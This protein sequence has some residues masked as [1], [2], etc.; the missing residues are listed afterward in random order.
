[1]AVLEEIAENFGRERSQFESRLTGPKQASWVDW[2]K[3]M[4]EVLAPQVDLSHSIFSITPQKHVS[5]RYV[6][7]NQRSML[8]PLRFVA[9]L[10]TYVLL[11]KRL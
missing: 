4:V 11:S 6:L 1:M 2:I 3:A 7:D 8:Q 9:V 5:V 10:L